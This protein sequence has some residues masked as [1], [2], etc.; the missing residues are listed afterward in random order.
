MLCR[1]LIEIW[2]ALNKFNK[3]LL[4]YQSDLMTKEQF[5]TDCFEKL[6]IGTRFFDFLSEE[7]QK[8]MGREIQIPNTLTLIEKLN[9][10]YPHN[11]IKEEYSFLCEFCHPN[12]PLSMLSMNS[13]LTTPGRTTEETVILYHL[14]NKNLTLT[15]TSLTEMRTIM[16]RI[17]DFCLH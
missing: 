14:W 9:Q 3:C 5:I 16:G 1:F 11:N 8:Q 10:S 7:M 12:M 6:F 17:T 13:L 4:A 15:L 2:A